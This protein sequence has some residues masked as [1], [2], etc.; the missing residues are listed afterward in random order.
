M[1]IVDMFK[2]CFSPGP[3]TP[4]PGRSSIFGREDVM[5]SN[6]RISWEETDCAGFSR[7]IRIERRNLGRSETCA[8]ISVGKSF[9]DEF[10]RKFRVLNSGRFGTFK[11]Y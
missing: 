11:N 10:T 9:V 5:V 2:P 4:P 8:R 6:H 1:L 7:S 3:L